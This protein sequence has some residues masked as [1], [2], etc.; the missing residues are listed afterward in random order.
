MEN[1]TD[2]HKLLKKRN[3]YTI[4]D[5]ASVFLYAL[6]L[7]LAVGLIFCYIALAF[8]GGGQT[9]EGTNA[10]V[11]L[12]NS[13]HGLMI[14][15][16]LL[17]QVV[18]ACIYLIYHKLSRIS[19]SATKLNIKKTKGG[20]AAMSALVGVICV[21]GFVLLIE[22]CFGQLFA[23]L[24]VE[25][26]LKGLPL[27]NVGWLFA[28]LL[29]LGVVPAICEELLFRGVIFQG[30]REKFS[31]KT[32]IIFSALLFA[33]IHQN[34]QQFIYPFIL[35]VVLSIVFEKT[36]NLTYTILIHMFNNFATIVLSFLKNTGVVLFDF[37]IAWW[38]VIL[39]I[40]AAAATIL[41]LWVIYKFYLNKQ[42]KI[43]IEKE[44]ELI[45]S[46]PIY[47]EKLPLSLVVGILISI[48]LIVINAIP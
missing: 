4:K 1:K 35:G 29:L 30:L 23:K 48:A 3:F 8:N 21:L 9:E 27:D 15:Y 39:A 28:N 16:M 44:G 45:Q 20:M 24:K 43:E 6:V 2:L 31:A 42:E 32:S 10:V 41:I 33:L 26:P 14:V 7:P 34:I 17:S 37:S 5:S 13:N 47:I 40:L 22:V 25:Q 18:F 19:F 12:L 38:V 46:P 11:E 36:N